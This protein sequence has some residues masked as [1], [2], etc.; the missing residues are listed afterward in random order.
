MSA[1]MLADQCGSCAHFHG[2][3]ADPPDVDPSWMDAGALVCD[4]FP[5]W[6][7]IPSEIIRSEFDHNNPHPDDNGIQRKEV[8]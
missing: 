1:P 7:G 3:T 2:E 8:I 5:A 4:A 6:P